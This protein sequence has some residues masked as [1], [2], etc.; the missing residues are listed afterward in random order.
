M[1]LEKI[2]RAVHTIDV[3]NSSSSPAITALL[4]LCNPLAALSSLYF[5]EKSAHARRENGIVD[6]C[7]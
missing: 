4:I 7:V 2:I 1:H 3:K 6:P 5:I